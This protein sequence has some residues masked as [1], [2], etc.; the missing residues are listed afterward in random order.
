MSGIPSLTPELIQL[1]IG[2]AAGVA[3]LAVGVNKALVGRKTNVAAAP[4]VANPQPLAVPPAPAVIVPPVVAA[5][6]SYSI[7]VNLMSDAW[8]SLGLP[9]GFMNLGPLS[10]NAVNRNGRVR[11]SVRFITGM[12]YTTVNALMV[13]N[14]IRIYWERIREIGGY[15][16]MVLRLTVDAMETHAIKRF[17]KSIKWITPDDR[18]WLNRHFHANPVRMFGQRVM[19]YPVDRLNPGTPRLNDKYF[20]IDGLR[21]DLEWVVVVFLGYRGVFHAHGMNPIQARYAASAIVLDHLAVSCGIEPNKGVPA[22]AP[23]DIGIPMPN[24][25]RRL[26]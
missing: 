6:V 9:V 24:R 25:L 17:S 2:V 26:T 10:T 13:F 5:L 20:E 21:F 7:A 19:V 1:G 22:Y 3:T 23:E 4:A 16:K 18:R 8:V 14:Q 12:D 15:R 11:G